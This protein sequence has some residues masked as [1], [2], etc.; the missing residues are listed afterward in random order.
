MATYRILENPDL[1]SA[2]KT[3]KEGLMR[4]HLLIIIGECYID[5]E[6]RSAS[7]LGLGERIVIIKQDGA[8]LVHRPKG[9]SPVNWQPSTTTIEVWLRSGEGLSL[10]A[11]RNRPREYLRILFTKIFTIIEG[12]FHDS[13]EFVMYLSES[14]IRD[15]I[16]ENPDL[17]EPGFKPL[18]KEKRIGQ[19][20]VDIY[21][22]D[23][24]NNHVLVE[25]KRVMGDREAVLQLYNYVENYKNGVENNVRGILLAPSF[26]PGALEL[27]AKLKLEFKEIDLRKLRLLSQSSKKKPNSTLFEY[28]NEKGRD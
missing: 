7:K 21:G 26:T 22:L 1:E 24:N 12:V 3:I 5:Y 17:L 16:F 13:A 2:L 8:V 10:L 9:Y 6:G 19:G 25:I 18:E 20:A 27:L 11:V 28:M 14:E 15:I 23:S 4:N